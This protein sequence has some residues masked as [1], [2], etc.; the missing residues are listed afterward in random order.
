[1]TDLAAI[2]L[3]VR[4]LTAKPSTNQMTN[5]ELDDYINTFY[6][7]DLPEHL[8]LLNL[9]ELFTF[10]TAPNIDTYAFTQNLNLTVEG[11]VRV[12]GY[13]ARLYLSR[14]AFFNDYPEIQGIQTLTTGTGIAGP[15]SGTISAIPVKKSRVLLSTVDS[16]GNSL[17]ALDNGTGTFTGDVVAGAT[18]NYITG[19]IGNLT[20]TSVVASGTIIRVQSVNYSAARPFALL[21]YDDNFQTFPVPDQAYRVE[22]D[23]YVTPT[24]FASTTDSP[25]LNEWWQLI[26]YGAAMKVFADELDL[27]SISKIQPLFDEQKRLMERRT[28]K[29]ISINRSQT[30]YADNQSFRVPFPSNI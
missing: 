6:Q 20:W 25:Q 10:T 27:E 28:L 12:G 21:F 9:K 23:T 11:P 1:M 14:E 16:A 22:M 4:R 2:R 18:I 13:T 3:K 8:R 24:A 15:Y 26:A 29:Q 30:I 19:A 7:Y 5:D 17:T